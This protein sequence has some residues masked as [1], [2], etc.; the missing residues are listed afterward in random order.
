MSSQ[1]FH[2]H[3][4]E[5]IF[6]VFLLSLAWLMNRPCWGGSCTATPARVRQYNCRTNW[7]SLTMQ[8]SIK[9]RSRDTA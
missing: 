8:S 3:A 9:R 1:P 4:E 7:G 6:F 5:A 2:R